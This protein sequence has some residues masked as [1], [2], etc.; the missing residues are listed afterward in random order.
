MDRPPSGCACY[1]VDPRCGY[2]PLDRRDQHVM[3]PSHWGKFTRPGILQGRQKQQVG[4]GGGLN[5]DPGQLP[6]HLIP[7]PSTAAATNGPAQKLTFPHRALLQTCFWSVQGYLIRWLLRTTCA[8]THI[9]CREFW[10]CRGR[11]WHGRT[12]GLPLKSETTPSRRT[13]NR[14]TTTFH[15]NHRHQIQN[16]FLL[17]PA[18][19]KHLSFE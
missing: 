8:R 18:V 13:Q 4:G 3:T 16:L 15:S 6:S 11:A 7:D 19:E 1:E 9:V 17:H 2:R 10:R 12:P 5:P 14:R